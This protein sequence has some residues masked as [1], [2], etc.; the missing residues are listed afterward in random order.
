MLATLRLIPATLLARPLG[1]EPLQA[2]R[3]QLTL[4]VR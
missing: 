2:T 3:L 1:W 4:S